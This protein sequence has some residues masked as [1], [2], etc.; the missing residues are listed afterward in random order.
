MPSFSAAKAI[1]KEKAMEKRNTIIS[2]KDLI[3]NYDDFKAVQG[4]SF[5]VYENEKQLGKGK[6]S[7]AVSFTFEN[8]EKTLQDKE[9][10]TI[11][12]NLLTAYQSELGAY[13]RK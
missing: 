8:L 5:D 11:I 9:V 12:E 13:L 6:R 10:D 7:Y 1:A 2:V 3:K 4:L